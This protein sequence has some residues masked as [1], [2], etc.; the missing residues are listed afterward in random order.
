M[1][2]KM[3]TVDMAQAAAAQAGIVL[4]KTRVPIKSALI[5]SGEQK[6]KAHVGDIMKMPTF[7]EG[8]E[9]LKVQ[10]EDEHCFDLPVSFNDIRIDDD[11]SLYT[12]ENNKELGT[13]LKYTR[14][15]LVQLANHI[16]PSDVSGFG[17]YLTTCPSHLIRE[18]F[19]YWHNQYKYNNA[20]RLTILKCRLDDDGLP[21]VR[22]AVSDIYKEVGD[23]RVLD[24]TKPFLPAGAHFKASRGDT[25][26]RYYAMW[27]N[28]VNQLK[29]GD[30]IHVALGIINSETGNGGIRFEPIIYQ[31]ACYNCTIVPIHGTDVSISH[32]GDPELRLRTKINIAIAQVQPF[33][34]MFK[35]AYDD[36]FKEETEEEIFENIGKIFKI[37]DK[38][39]ETVKAKF[40]EFERGNG[41][42]RA[43]VV[44]AI[45]RAAQEY[46]VETGEDMQRNAG[47]LIK[48]GWNMLKLS[49]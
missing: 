27:P 20:K 22:G 3:D 13:N 5:K 38:R 30:V 31:I 28:M 42:N 9:K 16:R 49:A 12:P 41:L 10:I 26:S 11:G 1:D 4:P 7:E 35:A 37:S 18:N 34:D 24:M 48:E 44:N 21:V 6:A 47:L 19:N 8:I 33:V 36:Q 39:M 25:K 40:D 2:G 29:V 14:N 45:T 17:K 23:L 46:D 32:I 43:G 15:A